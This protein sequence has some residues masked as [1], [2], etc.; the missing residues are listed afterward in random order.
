MPWY[1]VMIRGENF[2]MRGERDVERRGF[3]T[4]RFIEAPSE[5]K[6]EHCAVEHIR[7][8]ARLLDATLNPVDAPPEV[9]IE[10]FVEVDEDTVPEIQGGF[11]FFP[12][13]NNA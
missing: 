11:T 2:L 10:E 6:V 9:F 12:S 8:D 3:Y 13:E 4:S 1:R 5:D 7:A